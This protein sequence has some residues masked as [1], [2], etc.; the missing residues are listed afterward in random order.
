VHIKGR[1]AHDGRWHVTGES[2]GPMRFGECDLRELLEVAGATPPRNGRGKWCCPRC[3]SR[4]CLSVDLARGLFHCFHDGCD[5]SGNA[6]QLARQLGLTRRLSR[7]EFFQLR[8]HHERTDKMAQRLYA[9]W[10]PRWFDLLDWLHQL[11]ELI[12]AAQQLGPTNAVAW[13]ALE[14]VYS[15]RRAII[16]ELMILESAPPSLLIEF[17]IGDTKLRH[18]IVDCVIF[19]GGLYDGEGRFVELTS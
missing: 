7:Q 13:D 8:Q 3:R 6:L 18:S 4:A 12:I 11:N 17:L 5:F 14:T 16:T 2:T 19:N 1:Q 10:K 9:L 15:Q